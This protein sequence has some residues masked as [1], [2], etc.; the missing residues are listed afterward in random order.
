MEKKMIKNKRILI[1]QP[2]VRGLNGST[3]VTFEL[4]KTLQ[5]YGA[6]VTVYTCDFD[7]PAKEIFSKNRIKVETAQTN[8]K[9]KLND[10]DYIWV[11]S[12]ILPLSIIDALSNEIPNKLPIFI[13]LHMSGMEW[14][15]DEKPWIYNL[16]NNLSSL[17]LFISEEVLEINKPMLN[18]AIPKSFFRNPAPKDYFCRKHS[19]GSKLK[20][21]LI[22]SNHPPQEVLEAK[23]IL[24]Q[25]FGIKVTSLGENQ[26]NYT[27]INPTIIDNQDAVLTIAKTVP[28]CLVSGT[29]VYVYDAFGG[30]PGWLN[31]Q[32][33]E[34]A[35]NRNFS[36]YQNHIY[37]TYEGDG[38]QHK[39]PEQIA[40][41]IIEGYG[42]SLLFH[43]KH[44]QDFIEEF[45]IDAVLPNIFS[46]PHPRKIKKFSKPYADA[47][48][49]SERFAITRFELGGSLFTSNEQ[50]HNLEKNEKDLE[51][52][53]KKLTEFKIEAEQVFNSGAYKL[54]D[55]TIKPY[56]KITKR[57]KN[58]KK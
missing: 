45:G 12:Q 31:E 3:L 28:Y 24:S 8:P 41:E 15:P 29:P 52:Q 21:L 13:F 48:K 42:T 17:S 27:I 1:A 20:K 32:N 54:F 33:F 47:V 58:G 19:P 46:Q 18:Q 43:Q 49:A 4:A 53:I 5:D 6:I 57:R 56:K 10:F 55:K 37:P 39:S 26:D 11:H 40:N 30:G 14:I 35:K 2:L 25:K 22:V 9:Y 23:K 36:G 34:K 38:F 7:N 16:E 44:R 50:I 51:K